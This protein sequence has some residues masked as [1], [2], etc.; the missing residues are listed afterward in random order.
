[1]A[2]TTIA[3]I[4]LVVTAWIQIGQSRTS[5]TKLKLD[6]FNE[7]FGIFAVL[8][9]INRAWPAPKGFEWVQEYFG[10]MNEAAERLRKF[11]LLFP[12]QIGGRVHE[13]IDIRPKVK[14]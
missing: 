1:L 9:E 14:V 11:E 13:L 8:H 5:R 12:T 6:L 4:A 2:P 10:R 3:V 7:R